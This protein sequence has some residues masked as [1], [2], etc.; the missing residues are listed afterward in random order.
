MK[1][2]I[3]DIFSVVGRETLRST[4][5]H[6]N[7]FLRAETKAELRKALLHH[8]RR[9]FVSQCSVCCS[10]SKDLKPIELKTA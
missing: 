10:S 1:K 6:C 4:V 2:K 7:N 5:S 8:S 3:L 9:L